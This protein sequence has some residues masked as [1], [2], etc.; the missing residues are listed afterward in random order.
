MTPCPTD[1]RSGSCKEKPM[2]I[3]GQT[4][5]TTRVTYAYGA[6]AAAK[7]KSMCSILKGDWTKL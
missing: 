3:G 4:I 2:S 1:K 6:P 7:Q 5:E